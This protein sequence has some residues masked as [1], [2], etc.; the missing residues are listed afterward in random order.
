MYGDPAEVG[1]RSREVHVLEDADRR[2]ARRA[3]LGRPQAVGID[4]DD[5]AGAH[6]AD[7]L[8]AD[9]VE[10]ATL[11]GDHEVVAEP[12]ELERADPVRVAERHQRLLGDR[13]HR[14]RTL[15][16]RHDAADGLRQRPGLAGEECG[17]QLRVG[18]RCGVDPVAAELVAE[19]RGVR[20]V[21]VVP[22]R[23][24]ALAAVV[25][26]RLRVLPLR[27]A[28]RRVA[29][30]PDRDVAGKRL[31]LLLVEDAGDEPHLAERRDPAP[32][33]DGD[34]GRLLAA[35]LQRVEAEVG[36]PRDIALGRPD[37]EDPAH[38]D[39]LS[40]AA[41]SSPS[42]TPRMRR[43][44]DDADPPQRDTRPRPVGSARRQLGGTATIAWPP[45]SPNS[46]TG[47]SL[48]SSAAP[49]PDQIA[50]SASATASPPSATSCTSEA[51]GAIRH[52][53]PTR[54]ASAARSSAGGA[55]LDAP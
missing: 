53:Q 19:R 18:G 10:G 9:Q 47:S 38:Q 22:E 52:N 2:A 49:T 41:R 21:A 51:L 16:A 15:E 31:Q 12:A 23:D 36:E 5:L 39:S 7:V 28:G 17:D 29:R 37:T 11:G 13:D 42:G 25:H 34:P 4:R 33:G 48:R 30:V 35:V 27:R 24:P 6:L 44:A 8:G 26:D 14:V 54:A 32:V 55:P 20:Q 1:V 3:R 40:Q 43:A 45:P 46:S 50:A